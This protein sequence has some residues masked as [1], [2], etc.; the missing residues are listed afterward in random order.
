LRFSRP[1]GEAILAKVL[2]RMKVFPSEI[3]VSLDKL[4]E[5]LRRGLPEGAEAV[6]FDE[7]PIA[8]GLVALIATVAIPEESSGL[9]EKVENAIKSMKEVGEVQMIAVGRA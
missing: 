1:I 4:K 6:G 8:F 9:M 3:G 2:A 7:E 5:D